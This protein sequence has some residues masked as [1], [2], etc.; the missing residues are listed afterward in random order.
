MK[1][2][3]GVN[4]KAKL[5]YWPTVRDSAQLTLTRTD[6][7]LTPQGSISAI[8]I[9]N[10]GYKHNFSAALSAV[11]MVSDLF[12]GQRFRRIVSTAAVT[13]VYERRTQG[14]VAFIGLSYAFGVSYREKASPFDYDSG[15]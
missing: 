6:K 4:L 11:G 15:S 3:T 7:Q 1:S 12:N 13:Q 14:R 9:V 2:T 8:N 10:L 5:D